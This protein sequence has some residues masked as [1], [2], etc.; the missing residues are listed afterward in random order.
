MFLPT[1]DFESNFSAHKN[2]SNRTR[3]HKAKCTDNLAPAQPCSGAK[4]RPGCVI[5]RFC[6]TLANSLKGELTFRWHI[7]F[8]LHAGHVNSFLTEAHVLCF[9]SASLSVKC[10]KSREASPRGSCTIPCC[11]PVSA[12]VITSALILRRTAHCVS[13]VVS[14]QETF[15]SVQTCN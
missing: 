14:A 10:N 2:W 6:I 5:T 13:L 7:E 9:S 8:W 12:S 1:V 3:N 11:P 15:F 4:L